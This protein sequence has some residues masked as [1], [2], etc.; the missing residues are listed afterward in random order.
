MPPAH[1]IIVDDMILYPEQLAPPDSPSATSV[2]TVSVTPWPNAVIPVAFDATVSQGQRD[3]FLRVCSRWGARAPNVGCVVRT[4]EPNPLKSTT[5]GCRSV[6]DSRP[7]ATRQ[8][9]C[10]A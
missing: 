4:A 7:S 9:G 3:Q 8:P 2:F 5:T 6:A 10:F 1:E